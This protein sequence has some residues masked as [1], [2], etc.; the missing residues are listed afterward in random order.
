M[1]TEST[2]KNCGNVISENFC[3]NCGQKKYKR[4]DGKYL[5]DEIQYTLLHTNK[6]FFYTVKN[7]IKNPGKTTKNYLDGNRVKHYKPILLAFVLSGITTFISYKVLNMG[8]VMEA[9]FKEFY[10]Q[11]GQ[12]FTYGSI[13]TILAN[14]ISFLM[15]LMIP[16]A[17]V[18]S[19]LVFRKQGHNYYEH[20][21]INAFMYSFW[22]L[23]T[24]LILYPILYFVSSPTWFVYI[25][26]FSMP[27]F[28][29]FIVWFYKELYSHLS[30]G[31]VMM[32]VGM[33][34]LLGMICYFILSLTIG[35]LMAIYLIST[36]GIDSFAPPQ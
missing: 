36:K 24:A 29:P 28:I 30:S 23:F 31:K 7:L 33:M 20:V 2:C 27:L 22:A 11:K 12:N 9:F 21:V 3:A 1:N 34:S 19:Y 25:V 14:Y 32:K 15:M 18:L 8:E 35:I 16:M 13:N 10:Q 6:G 26:L 5:K 17:A 4:I